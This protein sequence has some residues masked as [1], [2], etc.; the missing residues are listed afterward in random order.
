MSNTI[1]AIDEWL[2]HPGY[3]DFQRECHAEIYQK[4]SDILESARS[5]DE[6]MF[7]R[8]WCAALSYVSNLRDI[9]EN[10]LKAERGDFQDEFYKEDI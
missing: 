3:E 7:A 8:G 4:Q 6:V 5:W 2:A 9:R 1:E 10:A